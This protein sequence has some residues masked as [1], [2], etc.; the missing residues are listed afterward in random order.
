MT[1]TAQGDQQNATS[2]Y[3]V[4][5]PE[6]YNKQQ[7]FREIHRARQ[8][9]AEHIAEMEIGDGRD[10]GTSYQLHEVTRLAHFVSLYILEL[11]PLIERS[12]WDGEEHIPDTVNAESLAEWVAV[13]GMTRKKGDERL[14]ANVFESMQIF[15]VANRFVAQVGMDL[16]LEEESGDAGFDYSD[17]LE[18]GPP[19]DGEVPEIDTGGGEGR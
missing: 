6:S 12:E 3:V 15:S 18:D 5:D 8:R 7:R 14:P 13:M 11:E 10:D 16:E 19:G 4:T 1:D 17:I 9:V 2:P